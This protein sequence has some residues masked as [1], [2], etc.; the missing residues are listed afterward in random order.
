MIKH[1]NKIWAPIFF[2]AAA[3]SY[4]LT[5]PENICHHNHEGHNPLHFTEMFYMWILMGLAHLGSW[6]DHGKPAPAQPPHP[7]V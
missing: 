7:E 1:Y 2:V 6:F 3:I 4:Y 5:G